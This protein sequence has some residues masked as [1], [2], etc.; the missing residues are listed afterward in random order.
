MAKLC[1]EE[2]TDSQGDVVKGRRRESEEEKLGSSE[3]MC[4]VLSSEFCVR[5]SESWVCG[6]EFWVCGSE[7]WVWSSG[8][9][10]VEGGRV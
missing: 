4:V 8:K 10:G 7:F 5:G 3:G 1:K 6:S 9:T 2:V